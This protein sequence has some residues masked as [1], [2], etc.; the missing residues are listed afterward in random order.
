MPKRMRRNG[1]AD[2]RSLS[3]DPASVLQGGNADM[4]ASFPA[5]E[6]PTARTS[7]LPIGAEDI[8][9]CWRQHRI[10]ISAALAIHDMDQFA[11]AID[12]FHLETRDFADPKPSCVGRGQGN[13]IAQSHHRIQETSDFIWIENQ[14]KLF[15]FAAT[16][17]PR[18]GFR[19]IERDAVEKPQSA[20]DLIDVRPGLFFR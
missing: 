6:K 5:R 19:L 15:G 20:S 7:T 4:L 10:A 12:R 18:N 8:E 2:P 13:A 9:K 16:G 14:G 11:R 3:R 1:F 17:D